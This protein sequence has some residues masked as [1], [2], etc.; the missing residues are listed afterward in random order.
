MEK[1]GS[2]TITNTKD[3]SIGRTEVIMGNIDE[4]ARENLVGVLKDYLTIVSG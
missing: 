3:D 2:I 1:G 4:A